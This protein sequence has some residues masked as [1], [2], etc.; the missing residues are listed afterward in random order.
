[1]SVCWLVSAVM[2]RVP[3][4][5]ND[6]IRA[7]PTC[8]R[9]PQVAA[10]HAAAVPDLSVVESCVLANAFPTSMAEAR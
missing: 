10:P 9:R 1:M 2:Y 5:T 8:L 7:W 6:M 4:S 3:P